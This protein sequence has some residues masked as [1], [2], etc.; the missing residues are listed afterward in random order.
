M[1][2]TVLMGCS[3]EGAMK[4]KTETPTKTQAKYK[5]TF[6]FKW[7]RTDFPLDYPSSAH[8]SSLIGW[9]HSPKSTFF[10]EGTIASDGIKNMAEFGTTST[11][12][13]EFKTKIDQKK[14]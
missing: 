10:K 1:T 11:L 9:S 3:D 12:L 8:F 6:T 13:N 5:V 4:T 7:N 14:V 2:Y